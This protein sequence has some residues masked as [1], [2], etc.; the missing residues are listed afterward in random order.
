MNMVCTD[1]PEYAFGEQYECENV[2]SSSVGHDSDAER[3][4]DDG[5]S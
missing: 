4:D 1:L 2:E 5:Q 3:V